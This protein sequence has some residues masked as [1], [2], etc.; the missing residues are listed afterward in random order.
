MEACVQPVEDGTSSTTIAG[1]DLATGTAK[2]RK[3]SRRRRSWEESH[4]LL[5][6]Y[7]EVH[8]HINVPQSESPLGP[9]VNRQRIEHSRYVH[10]ENIRR[11][12]RMGTDVKGCTLVRT[13]MTPRRKAMLDDVGFVWD[14]MGQSWN[15]HYDDLCE[16]H[17][18]HGHCVVPRSNGRLG[19]WVKKQRIEY[20]KYIQDSTTRRAQTILTEDRVKKLDDVGFVWDVRERQFERRLGQ[21]RLHK[22]KND[23]LI[24]PRS[25]MD[26]SLA[27]WVRKYE[28][29]YRKYLNA[30]KRCGGSMDDNE[31]LLSGIL[32]KN[33][34][35][36]LENVG[37][38]RGM[39]DE[40]PRVVMSSSSM[41]NSRVTWEERYDELEEYKSEHG[42]C[43][44]P[45]NYGPLGS[46]VRAQRHSMKEMKTMGS[47]EYGG[48]VPMGV[49]FQAT[50]PYLSHERV[51]RLDRL[52]FVWDVH[53]WQWNQTY[54]ELLRYTDEHGHSNVPMSYGKLGLWVFNQRSDYHRGTMMS[55]RVELLK[56]VGFEFELGQKILSA[57]DECWQMRMNDLKEYKETWGSFNVKQIHNPS[58]YNWIQHQKANLQRKKLKKER[59]DAL[60]SIGFLET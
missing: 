48:V 40:E 9:W 34:C 16:F 44:V 59:E 38:C 20:K 27:A 6:A 21:L 51:D 50:N 8:G 23:G 10:N 32:P 13:S 26:G 14:A 25:M 53:E 3:S 46:W 4:A 30:A 31:V 5:C 58:L 19:A 7:G 12:L 11:C 33:R 45:K 24:D 15:A 60:R 35:V 17:R 1:G 55:D 56:T 54:H 37:F 29:Q 43:V 18:A 36:A 28:R 22:E 41:K 49:V 47:L 57:A 39:F 42:H 52:G 2:R